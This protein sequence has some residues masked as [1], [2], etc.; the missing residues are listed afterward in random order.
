MASPAARDQ[1]LRQMEQI[2]EGIK[3]SR[4]KMEKKKQ[5]NKM[6]RDQL[7]DQY[8]ELLEKQRLYFKTVKEFK[9][10]TQSLVGPPPLLRRRWRWG[11]ACCSPGST[12]SLQPEQFCSY[13]CSSR[14]ATGTRCCCPRWEPRPPESPRHHQ[15]TAGVL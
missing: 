14:R 15:R 1:F 8:L 2:V 13:I 11:L 7:N 10:V 4:M 6:R 3:Q 9:E 5:E 12:P